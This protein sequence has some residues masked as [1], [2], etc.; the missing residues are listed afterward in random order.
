MNFL[1]VTVTTGAQWRS[2]DCRV[3]VKP[4]VSA[5][6]ALV[7]EAWSLKMTAAGRC[8]PLQ[9]T[10]HLQ[11]DGGLGFTYWGRDKNDHH[12]VDDIL[13]L[14]FIQWKFEFHWK[15]DPRVQLII[16][17]SIGSNNGLAPNRRQA[18]TWTNAGFFFTD[19]YMRHS[20]SMS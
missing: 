11:L 7:A 20:A 8:R 10:D 3:A 18:I 5:R 9:V 16:K 15:L 2:A 13:E 12:F 1:D 6:G 19:A 4:R 14:F 17:A